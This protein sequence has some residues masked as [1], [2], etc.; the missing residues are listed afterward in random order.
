MKEF[1]RLYLKLPE[2]CRLTGLSASTVRRRVRDGS[3][4]CFQPGGPDHVLL[5]KI[6]AL[7]HASSSP[8]TSPS[9]ADSPKVDGDRLHGPDAVQPVAAQSHTNQRGPG[10]KWKREL[11]AFQISTPKSTTE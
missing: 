3:I 2:F 11:D 5:F 9:G 10:P 4:P 1:T 7:K 6:D 8:R